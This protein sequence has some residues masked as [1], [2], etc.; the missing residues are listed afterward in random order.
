MDGLLSMT[1]SLLTLARERGIVRLTRNSSRD[2]KFLDKVFKDFLA[3][4][5]TDKT[6]RV[7]ES[8]DP[9]EMIVYSTLKPFPDTFI[10]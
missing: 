1:R 6:L 7:Y 4:A 2:T 9:Y 10:V 5:K 8:Q 3:L